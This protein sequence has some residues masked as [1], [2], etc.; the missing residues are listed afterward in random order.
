MYQHTQSWFT[1][2]EISQL[3][4]LHL[5]NKKPNRILEIGCFEGLSSVFFA[6]TFLDHPESQ[7]TCVDPFLHIEAN[8][9]APFMLQ[10]EGTR[11]VVEDNFDFNISHCRNADKIRVHKITSDAFFSTIESTV[12]YT[13][14]YVDG[15]HE[16]EILRRD[17]F[18]SFSA[19]ERGGIMWVDDYLGGDGVTIKNVVDAFFTEQTGLYEIVHS[20]YQVALTKT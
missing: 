18:N 20:G 12:H 15:C 16:P 19:L 13:F 1:G 4:Y 17:L 2:S 9:H 14:I 3:A 11:S 8:D 7:L 5:D 6:D 10:T